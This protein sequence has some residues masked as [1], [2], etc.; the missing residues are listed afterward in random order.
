MTLY[1]NKISMTELPAPSRHLVEFGQ[2]I[3]DKRHGIHK[4]ARSFFDMTT[5]R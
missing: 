1:L 3:D 2:Q 5:K 4:G